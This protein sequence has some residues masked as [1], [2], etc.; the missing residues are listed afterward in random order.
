VSDTDSFIDEV[1]EEVRRDQLFALFHKYGWIG[2]LAIVLIVGAA[3][4]KEWQKAQAE[5]SAQTFGDALV[6]AMGSNDSATRAKALADVAASDKIAGSAGRAAVA[7]LMQSA[8]AEAA[9][10]R[11][12]AL[13]LLKTVSDNADVPALYRDLADLKGLMLD[14]AAMDPAARNQALARLAVPG[15]PYRT[16]AEEQ[17]ALILL[18]A[19]KTDEAVAQ[20]RAIAED[21]DTP[22][23][24]RGRVG[25]ILSMLGAE[26]AEG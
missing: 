19:G 20:F 2:V 23:S 17:Q 22:Q 4:W 6:A 24:Q 10:D 26:P 5:A 13:A 14:G 8:E 16:L 3:S 11:A 21:A 25:Q 7:A 15:A 12:G 9:G 1:T 18:D